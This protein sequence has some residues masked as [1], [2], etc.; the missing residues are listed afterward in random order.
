MSNPFR[1]SASRL[2]WLL[3]LGLFVA[4]FA[5]VAE[6]RTRTFCGVVKRSCGGHLQPA[7][8]S[9]AACDA[10]H[11]SYSGSPFPITIDCPWPI[12]DVKV[13]SGCY[14]SRPSCD[15]CSAK[16]QIPCPQETSQWCTPGCDAGLDVR[17]GLCSDGFVSIPKS[18]PNESCAPG[19]GID[20]EDGLQCTLALTCSHEPAREG[21]TC[22]VKV[23]CA[24]GLYCQAGVPQI[25]RR[26]RTVGEGCSA[27]NP[28]AENLSCEACFTESCNAPFQCFPNANEGAIT[29]QQC[30]KLYSPVIADGITGGDTTF[31]W[32]GGNGIGAVATESQA[33]G[34][35]YGQ[36]GEFGCFTALCGGI[37]SDVGVTGAFTSLGFYTQ[38]DAVGGTSFV[39]TQTAQTPFK[40]LNFSTSQVFERFGNDFP[41]LTGDLIGTEDVLGVG[42]GINPSPFTAGSFY[43]E[44]ILDEIGVDPEENQPPPLE[45]PPLEQIVN[46]DFE[47][48]LFGWRCTNGGICGWDWDSPV[49]AGEH[50]LRTGHESAAG[51]RGH[52]WP[53]DVELCEG[54]GRRAVPAVGVDPDRGGRAGH[55]V[56]PLELERE[57]HGRRGRQRFA[58][59][60][61]ARRRLA[62]TDD[63][64]G[65]AGRREDRRVQRHGE[66]E[67]RIRSG[68]RDD[69]R[70]GVRPGA[71]AG[72]RRRRR[73]GRPAG[74]PTAAGAR[75]ALSAADPRAG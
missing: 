19:V 17:F 65:G 18:G 9:G 51:S 23:P 50:G 41:P 24:S 43:C 31:T 11:T 47:T 32:A 3:L 72:T 28:C 60:L 5:S 25:C 59:I 61:A 33:F 2:V 64:G 55:G 57:L 36:N 34:V 22:D 48:D 58:R 15:D 14:D 38:F 44:T 10:G 8:T 1:C 66:S 13:S 67:P 53:A 35:A 68:E 56:P 73:G 49:R 71:V 27:F 62:K 63:G 6:A 29:E 69:H 70:Q 40:F 45:L 16:G 21:E 39:N 7:C 30:Q 75:A 20:C 37:F 54:A 26:K 42:A 74:P 46:P 52:E 12:K 4:G